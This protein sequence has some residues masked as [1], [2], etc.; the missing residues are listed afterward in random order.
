[1]LTSPRPLDHPERL[2]ALRR[3][4]LLDSEAE[5]SFDRITRL[6][7]R[8]LGAPVALFS[9]V[10]DHHQFFKSAIG[11][12]EPYATTRQTPL[13]HSFCQ[14]VVTSGAP[15]VVDDAREHPLVRD[16]L[17]V[18]E[19]GV[20]AYLGMPVSDRN[21]FVL[22]SLCA[23]EAQRREWSEDDIKNLSD[24]AELVMNEIA[25]RE[26]NL[27]HRKTRLA[28]E[29]RNHALQDSDAT[30][31]AL[32]TR[33]ESASRAKAAFLANMSH[34]IRTPMNAIVG[35]TELL[36]ES[37]LN[38]A[39]RDYTQ[40]IRVSGESL[41]VL[42]NDILDFSKM[43]SGKLELEHAPFDLHECV[44]GAI[45]LCARPAAE[46]NLELVA[47]IDPALPASVFGDVTRLRQILVNLVGN[48]VKFTQSGEVVL[49][50]S[51]AGGPQRKDGRTLLHFSVRDTGIG[52]PANR[53]DHLF[54]SFS[55]VDPSTTRRFGGTGLGLAI[56]SRL[57]ALM[58]GRISVVSEPGRGSE[59][60]FDVPFEPVACARTASPATAFLQGRR[61]L[62]VDDHPITLRA[63]ATEAARWGL[64]VTTAASAAEALAILDRGDAFETAVF[65]ARLPGIGAG[66]FA[67]EIRRRRN[68]EQLALIALTPL[69]D[70]GREFE[71]SRV[72]RLVNKPV[73][74]HELRGALKALYVGARTD[75]QAPLVITPAF[76]STLATRFPLRV[77]LAEDNSVNQRVARLLLARFGYD[78]CCAVANGLEVLE[79]VETRSY[80]IV[81]L[82]VQMPELDG[83]ETARRLC[84]SRPAERRPWIVA[85][86]ANAM[87][88][89]REICLEA[90]MDDYL[91]KPLAA[92]TLAD[93]LVRAWNEV[94]ARRPGSA[95]LLEPTP[96][97]A[98]VPALARVA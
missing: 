87:K 35:M 98:P 26:E 13:S 96:I 10:D 14:H 86:T 92:K 32:A 65:D 66:E 2:D 4:N 57:V 43:E 37:A 45:D 82:D 56:C 16:N 17:A 90:G 77:L 75:V 95:A 15:L 68:A 50:I 33:A 6:A 5:P 21:G 9:L 83:L 49:T 76:D 74:T 7:S 73:K 67:R 55:Q 39:Q 94:T 71:G 22:G 11:L 53:R 64:E 54:Q 97:F 79:A 1:V 52:I 42:I 3:L 69:G 78:D 62:L 48:A 89:D 47:V 61:L 31:R 23:I 72:S 30:A 88:G 34:E 27:E 81:L 19:L 80:D 36:L 18:P 28:L 51:P 44:E 93:A 12:A 58:D 25:L 40:T 29:A 38:P 24:L 20:I 70:D 63:L 85:L 60:C 46:K 91:A 8:L 84:A 59:F 41:L